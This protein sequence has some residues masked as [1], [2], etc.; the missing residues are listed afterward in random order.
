MASKRFLKK[1]RRRFEPP[2]M[3]RFRQH[4]R[5]LDA[6]TGPRDALQPPALRMRGKKS[7]GIA[8]EPMPLATSD[9]CISILVIAAASSNEEPSPRNLASIAARIEQPEHA[10]GQVG[11]HPV[12]R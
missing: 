8:P 12:V 11:R 5:C 6:D 10:A 1:C 9:N 4:D 3:G 7:R 2:Q